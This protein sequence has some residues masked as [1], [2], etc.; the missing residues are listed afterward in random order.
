MSDS[1]PFWAKEQLKLRARF[2]AWVTE[3]IDKYE[4]EGF[5]KLFG[6]KKGHG[7]DEAGGYT[8]EFA[9]AH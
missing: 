9:A 2:D 8:R 3:E 1:I 5:D 6:Q 7:L 4:A